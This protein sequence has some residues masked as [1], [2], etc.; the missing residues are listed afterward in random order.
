MQRR[1]VAVRKHLP[2]LP[3][4][5]GLRG[6]AALYVAIGHICSMADPSALAGRKSEAPPWLQHVSAIFG[7]G[8]LAVAA[9][10]VLSGYCLEIAV[11]GRGEG[12]LG[13]LPRFF[14]R[15]AQR[16][17][18]AYYGCLAISA[19]V[20]I[21][22][23]KWLPGMPFDIYRPVTSQVVWSHIFLYHNWSEATMYRI[24]G[25]LW[26]IALEAQ[27]YLL[28]PLLVLG[29]NKI[30]RLWT[31]ILSVGLAIAIIPLWPNVMKSYVWFLP[32]FAAGMAG[33]HL[34]W[35]P[36][37][38]VGTSPT[39]GAVFALTLFVACGIAVAVGAPL[40]VT[41]CLFGSAMVFVCY[42]LST[43]EKGFLLR[44]LSNR[45]IVALGTFSYSLY[46]MHHPI[47]QILFAIKPAVAHDP[48]SIWI[49]LICCLP[50][51]L[52]LS[53]LYS[54]GFERPFVQNKVAPPQFEDLVP[55]SLPLRSLDTP[56]ADSL[57]KI[58]L[59]E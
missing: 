8:H 56:D 54:L 6:V 10:I 43:V 22:L 37:L 57:H 23:E 47:Q 42:A 34:A 14:L 52:V 18:P 4:L 53:W 11:F 19:A 3:F 24:N 45:A 32:L 25:V 50:V 7:Y 20:T 33:A 13:S 35:R 59:S 30:G 21:G 41:D 44:M 16:I 46:L 38:R 28:F 51:I 9:F 12:K 15:R 5:E 17:L 40:W 29:L 31:L 1:S 27:L 49:Y 48:G 39:S 26:S 55:L 36:H 2:R 58:T